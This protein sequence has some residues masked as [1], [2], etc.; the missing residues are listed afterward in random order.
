MQQQQ[1]IVNGSNR[2]GSGSQHMNRFKP[3]AGQ[4]QGGATG[5]THLRRGSDGNTSDSANEAEAAGGQPRKQ[6]QRLHVNPDQASHRMRAPATNR[7]VQRQS[8]APATPRGTVN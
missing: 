3:L 5:T 7:P 2:L 1:Q 4:H 6:A 8:L